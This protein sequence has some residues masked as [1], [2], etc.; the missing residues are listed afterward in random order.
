MC[1]SAQQGP[2]WLDLCYDA[3]LRLLCCNCV[4][5]VYGYRGAV[6]VA[7]GEKGGGVYG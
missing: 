4:V 6:A 2:L 3:I 5:V 1:E 7:E